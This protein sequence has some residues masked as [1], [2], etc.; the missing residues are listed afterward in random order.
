MPPPIGFGEYLRTALSLLYNPLGPY[1]IKLDD[2]NN[3]GLAVVRLNR[4][5]S[6]AVVL[7]SV[8]AFIPMGWESHTSVL[9]LINECF[10]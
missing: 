8:A 4:K 1:P 2:A 9:L 6:S 5:W 3:T 10:E 7:P